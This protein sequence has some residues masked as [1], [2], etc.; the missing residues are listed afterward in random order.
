VKRKGLTGLR[1]YSEARPPLTERLSIHEAA[2]LA[3]ATGCPINLL[4]LSSRDALRA[5]IDVRRLYPAHDI[6][7]ETTL[8]HLA[9]AYDTGVGMKGKVNPPIRTA[10]DAAFLWEGI[11]NGTVDTVASDHACCGEEHKREDDLWG[12][13]PGFGGSSLLYPILI[14]EGCHK[15]GISPV[16]VAEMVSANP[17]RNFG[18]FPRKGTISIGADADFA[19]VD[20]EKDQPITVDL[21]MSAQ[22][23]TPFEGVKAKGWPTQTIVRGRVVFDHGQVKTTPL[24]EYLKRPLALHSDEEAQRAL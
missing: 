1:A 6:R 24:G 15:R 23:H 16:R 5:G 4:H 12:S 19:I 11:K 18:L 9:L 7:L 17:A 20:M 10:R 2:I 14:S 22:D 21:C 13:L 8:H 3:D